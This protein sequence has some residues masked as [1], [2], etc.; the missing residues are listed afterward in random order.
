MMRLYPGEARAGTNLGSYPEVSR[1]IDIVIKK[2]NESKL[3]LHP[4]AAGELSFDEIV[5]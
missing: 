2:F 3:L 1:K 4:I 5:A